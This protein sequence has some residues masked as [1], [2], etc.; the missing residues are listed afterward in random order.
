[1]LGLQKTGNR[2]NHE[3]LDIMKI[4]RIKDLVV[5]DIIVSPDNKL[6]YLKCSNGALIEVKGDF[7]G[8][9]TT[10]ANPDKKVM[11]ERFGGI[12]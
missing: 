10:F 11:F 12:K 8:Y 2:A 7:L 5:G 1:M 6:K 9:T 4:K 3:R